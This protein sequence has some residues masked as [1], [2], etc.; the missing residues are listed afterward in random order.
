MSVGV[1]V[2]VDGSVEY[3]CQHAHV[4]GCICGCGESEV[5][6]IKAIGVKQGLC[7][8]VV[9]VC[10]CGWVCVLACVRIG[11][12]VSMCVQVW[13]CMWKWGV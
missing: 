13:V 3:V 4:C 2:Y 6:M 10:V 7:G 5:E 8:C 12:S 11:T 1:H 9:S